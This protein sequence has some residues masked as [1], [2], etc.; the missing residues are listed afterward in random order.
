MEKK[1]LKYIFSIYYNYFT[2]HIIIYV[3]AQTQILETKAKP[4]FKYENNRKKNYQ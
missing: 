4:L 2:S 3:Y 1:N